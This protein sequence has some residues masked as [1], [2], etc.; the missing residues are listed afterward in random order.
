MGGRKSVLDKSPWFGP[1]ATIQNFV[2][3]TP[4]V[5]PFLIFSSTI[6]TKIIILIHGVFATLCTFLICTRLKINNFISAVCAISFALSS[7]N[8][9]Y[10]HVDDWPFAFISYSMLPIMLLLLLNLQLEGFSKKL[11]NSILLGFCGGIFLATG[12]AS[13]TLSICLVLLVFTVC[14]IKI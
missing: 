2:G 1:A 12:L 5:L 9:N 8:I 14:S 4:T 11:A 13:H 10:L 7:S 3:A 6:A